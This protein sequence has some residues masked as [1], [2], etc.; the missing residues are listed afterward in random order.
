MANDEGIG[1]A[2]ADIVA[3]Y[4]YDGFQ[5]GPEQAAGNAR[6]ILAGC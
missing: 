6:G 1:F 4:V 3:V 5:H 2:L